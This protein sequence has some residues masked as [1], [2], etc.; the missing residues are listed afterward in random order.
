MDFLCDAEKRGLKRTVKAVMNKGIPEF[1]GDVVG[2][3]MLEWATLEPIDSDHEEV[4][5][6]LLRYGFEVPP[7]GWIGPSVIYLIC[8]RDD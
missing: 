6:V 4:T 3:A 8:E 1:P 7:G 2:R 5:G